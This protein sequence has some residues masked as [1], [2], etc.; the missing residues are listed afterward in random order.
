MTPK[1]STFI[2]HLLT[3]ANE[4]IT[5]R[6]KIDIGSSDHQMIFCTRKIKKDK[7]SR[8]KQISFRSFKD[9]SVD[10]YEKALG[11]VTFPDYEKFHNINKAY[12][13]FFII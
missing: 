10:K 12:N 6:G 13:D 3:N 2:D 1:T 7:V 5:Q 8:H 11:K 4:K 9:N